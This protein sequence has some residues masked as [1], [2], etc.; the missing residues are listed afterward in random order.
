[1]ER[2]DNFNED[3]SYIRAKKRVEELKGY[4]KHLAMYLIINTVI[5]AF[6]IYDN[7]GDGDT[8]YEALASY[9]TYL[10]WFFW[11]IGMFFH[12]LNTFGWNTFLGSKWQEKKVNEYMNG[13][14]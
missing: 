11:G 9:N 2:L 1:M 5:S 4:Y 8:F 10:V 13:K 14:R 3:R 12:T 6:R 7:M